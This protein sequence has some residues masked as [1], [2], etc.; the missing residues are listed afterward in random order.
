L[1]KRIEEEIQGKD[2][3]QLTEN[4]MKALK[5]LALE[6]ILLSQKEVTKINGFG[7]SF[8][9][10]LLHA[11]FPNLIPILDS[12]VI[13]GSGIKKVKKKQQVVDIHKY[14]EELIEYFWVRI[15]KSKESIRKVDQE[16]FSIPLD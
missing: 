7:S 14:Y 4:E 15:S 11:Y 13:N 16:L 10:A 3:F 2:L 9:S 8:S 6:F 1:I 12:R 5:E